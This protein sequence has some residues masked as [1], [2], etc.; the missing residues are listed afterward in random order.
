MTIDVEALL[1]DVSPDSPCGEDLSYDPAYAELERAVQGT[2]EKQVGDSVIP[3]EEPDWRQVKKLALDLMGRT[4][5]L[6]VT[7]DLTLAQMQLEG[8]NGLRD[9][10]ALISGLLDQHWESFHPQLDAEDDNDPTE[11][12]NIISSLAPEGGFQDPLKFPQRLLELPLCSS[13]QLGRFNMRSVMLA[14]GE[15]KPVGEETAP[16]PAHIDAAFASAEDLSANAAAILE[17]EDALGRINAR[18][19][20]CVGA[21]NA[22]DLGRFETPVKQIRQL[23]QQKAPQAFPGGDVS[24]AGDAAPAGAEGGSVSSTEAGTSSALSG[25]VSSRDD[26][27]RVL[28][29]VCSYYNRHEPSSPVPLLIQRARRLVTKG[30]MDIVKDMSPDTVQQIQKVVGTVDEGA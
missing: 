28:D 16:D 5:D 13:P 12:M 21:A 19:E 25:G 20:E 23:L 6:R 22:P 14:S 27:I 29:L 24:P 7:L 30:F 11:R 9:G 4:K 1:A 26:V 10:L 3:A 17:V 2:P 8:L 18:L 15:L